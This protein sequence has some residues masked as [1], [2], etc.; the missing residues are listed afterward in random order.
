MRWPRSKSM[1]SMPTLGFASTLPIERYM[2]FLSKF[3]NATVCSST[4]RTNPGSPPLYEQFGNPASSAVAR[5]NMSRDS[6]NALS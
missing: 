4:T 3:G 2:P 1:N 5:K 6:M